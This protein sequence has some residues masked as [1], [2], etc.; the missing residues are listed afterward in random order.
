[1]AF[2]AWHSSLSTQSVGASSHA[3]A[4]RTEKDTASMHIITLFTL[5]LLPGTF[6]G[7]RLAI[8][9]LRR[10]PNAPLTPNQSFFSTPIIAANGP[11]IKLNSTLGLLFLEICLPMMMFS[12]I[13]WAVY[14]GFKTRAWKKNALE[15]KNLLEEKGD[16]TV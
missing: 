7:V 11:N 5:L 10:L 8:S 12:L 13:V 3:I 15:A 16:Q 1:M 4:Q 6:L 9:Y 14:M 2:N